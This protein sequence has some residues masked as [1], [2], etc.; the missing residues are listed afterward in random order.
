LETLYREYKDQAQF[1]LVY[2]REAHASDAR[3]SGSNKRDGVIYKTPK[4][5]GERAEIAS[6][7]V[8]SLKLSMPVLLDDM[9]NTVQRLY[10]GWPA[11]SCII[12]P[13]GKI[14]FINNPG[15]RGVDPTVIEKALKPLLV[16]PKE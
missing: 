8:K 1:F 4:T 6:D 10:Q 13:D 16:A 12:N 2:V 9:D 5:L 14:A 3:Q 11:R 15:P 7:C